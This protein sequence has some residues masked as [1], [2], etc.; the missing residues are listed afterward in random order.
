MDAA[1]LVTDIWT[2]G[3]AAVDGTTSVKNALR[4]HNIARP[5][6]IIAVGKAAA[7]MALAA[8][9]LFG[10]D[11]PT[12]VITKYGHAIPFS[13]HPPP[14]LRVIEAAHPVPDANSLVAGQALWQT[15]HHMP[16]SSHLLM[17]VSGG[18]S[19]LTEMPANG[20][21]LHA[22]QTENQ[23]LLSEGLDIHTMNARRKGM[24]LI[25][26]GRLL[27]GFTG[28]R[29]T[30][31][32]ISDVQGDALTVIGSG[33]GNAPDNVRFSFDPYIVA[34]NAIARQ[35]AAKRAHVRGLPVLSNSEILYD[36]VYHL[37]KSLGRHLRQSPMGI[38]IYGGEPTIQ[39]PPDPG[40][41]GRNQ[42]LALALSR[43]IHGI[44]D[45]TVLV[46]GT[47]GTDGPTN[48]AGGLITGE[49]WQDH[50]A[51]YLRAADSGRYL[52]QKNA[53]FTTGPTGT[54]VMDLVIALRQ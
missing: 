20:L 42:A 12:L 45:M 36:D 11:L 38:H 50:A 5:D 16:A 13:N 33:I 9:N 23:R 34:S 48:A 3:V 14:T 10:N 17:L 1:A 30:T 46:A 25:K 22:L 51:S 8:H 19:S 6:Q 47:D 26:G 18:A 2:A 43:E 28:A 49:T 52:A 32:A 39:L 4:S 7:S 15:V 24:S 53:L 40:Q 31:L 35:H 44:D 37:A 54:N 29:V 27:E 41:G 21:S